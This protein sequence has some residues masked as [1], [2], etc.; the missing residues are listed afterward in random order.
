MIY[1]K[2]FLNHVK[3]D[4]VIKMVFPSISYSFMNS[5]LKETII[6]S[7]RLSYNQTSFSGAIIANMHVF[8]L[9][10]IQSDQLQSYVYCLYNKENYVNRLEI[11]KLIFKVIFK[12]LTTF[13][14][15]KRHHFDTTNDVIVIS[16]LFILLFSVSV[17][18]LQF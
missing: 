2:E 5:A 6:S 13:E 8:L 18:F 4:F 7:E 14:Q 12:T 11:V 17:T 9:M 3:N 16:C 1:L 15:F 10:T